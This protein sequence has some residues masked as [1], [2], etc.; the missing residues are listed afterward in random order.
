[1]T[2]KPIAI[3][4]TSDEKSTLEAIAKHLIE[5]QLAGCVQI[6]GPVNSWYRWEGSIENSTEWQCLIKTDAR[7]I[8]AIKQ[9]ILK[10]HNYEQPQIVA[11]EISDG[12]SGYLNW[13][14]QNTQPSED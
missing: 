2:F 7:H 14:Q 1:M 4:T 3:T 13:I 6:S 9:S 10:L 12:S 8:D 11:F 5:R